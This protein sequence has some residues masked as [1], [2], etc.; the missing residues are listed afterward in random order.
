MVA[1]GKTLRR[2]ASPCYTNTENRE[3]EEKERIDTVSEDP[4]E[5]NSGFYTCFVMSTLYTKLR[6][7]AL[8]E[9]KREG[10][11]SRAPSDDTWIM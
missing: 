11:S 2:A 5:N 7:L 3:N 10:W 8:V 6:T 1:L 9:R 4:E